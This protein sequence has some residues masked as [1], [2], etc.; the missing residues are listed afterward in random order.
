MK[1][2]LANIVAV[3]VVLELGNQ[4]AAHLSGDTASQPSWS[5]DLLLSSTSTPCASGLALILPSLIGI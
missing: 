5:R 2:A 3:F 1:T 4:E